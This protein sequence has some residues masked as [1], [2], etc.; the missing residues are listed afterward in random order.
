M[1]NFKLKKKDIIMLW[2]KSNFLNVIKGNV[3]FIRTIS[4][5]TTNWNIGGKRMTKLTKYKKIY[6]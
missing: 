3:R 1:I 4:I 2:K 5:I 6:N